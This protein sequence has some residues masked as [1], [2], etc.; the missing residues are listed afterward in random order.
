MRVATAASVFGMPE[1]AVGI[2]SVVEA[3]LL[4]G[5]IGWGR[6]RR[7][8]HLAE[9]IGGA[10]AERWGLLEKVVKDEAELDRAVEEWVGMLVGMG[11]KAIR[12]QKRLMLEWERR[13]GVEG[14]IED[15]IEAFAEAFEDGGQEP[16][17]F[18]GKFLHRKRR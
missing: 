8:V 14:A 9:R 17:E 3:A 18:M 10:E 4:P 16:K 11:P 13:A 7:L 15:G 5:L 2:P 1:V 12:S 6:T